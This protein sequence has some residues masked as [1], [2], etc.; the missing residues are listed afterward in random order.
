MT[1]S[2]EKLVSNLAKEGDAKFHVLKRHI[3]ASKVP[4]LLRKG[5]YPYD[6]MDDMSK[7]HKRQLPSKEAFLS[8]LTEEHISDED[9]Q[10]AQIVFTSFQLQTLGKYHDL[11]LLSDVLLLAD[12]FENFRS[13]CMNYYGLDPSHY[14]TS[15]GLAW[16]AC[17]KMTDVVLELLTD[18]GMYL[19]VEEGIRGGISM[20]SN[21]YGKANNLYVPDFDSTQDKNYIMYLDANNLYGWA[22]SQPLPTHEFFWLTEHEI[23]ELN[24]MSIPDDGE[25][26]YILEV[27]LEYPKEL[28][29]LHSDYPLA[30][31]TMKVTPNMLSSYCQQLAQDLNLGGAPVPK[32]VPNLCYILHYRNLKLYLDLGMKLTKIHRALGFAQSTWLKSYIDFNTEKRKQ[33]SNDFEKDFFKLMNNAVFGKTME[34]LR[35]LVT[36]PSK[37]NKLTASPAFDAFHIFSEDLAAICM[38]KTNLYLNRP[39]YVGFTILDLSK[40]LMYDFHSNYM[41]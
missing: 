12:V 13:V 17:L 41:V 3:E 11:Y 39:I 5:V 16:S 22:M 19:F 18:P 15:P 31:E 20:I 10:H 2:L 24:V 14:Y 29:D 6:Y 38:K 30:P 7:F 35:K 8:Q 23:E 36:N 9:Y 37:L 26:G 4:L 27:D 28:H 25:E 40:V 32:L 1:A 34:N 21:R 33:A